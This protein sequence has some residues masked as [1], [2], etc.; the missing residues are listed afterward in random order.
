MKGPVAPRAL[1]LQDTRAFIV[2][3]VVGN[4]WAVLPL[5]VAQVGPCSVISGSMTNPC[6][7]AC[8]SLEVRKHPNVVITAHANDCQVAPVG[9][10]KTIFDGVSFLFP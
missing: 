5:I 10:R 2:A 4:D 7:G 3:Y 1:C 9:R 8:Y 6:G